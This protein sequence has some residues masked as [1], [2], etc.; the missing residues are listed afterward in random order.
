LYKRVKL[1]LKA[2]R[3]GQLDAIRCFDGRIWW[4]SRHLSRGKPA[5]GTS[6]RPRL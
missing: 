2:V 5:G 3:A 6:A 1:L 4:L